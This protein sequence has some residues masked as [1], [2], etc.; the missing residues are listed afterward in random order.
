MLQGELAISCSLE[1]LLHAEFGYFTRWLVIEAEAER[2][3]TGRCDRGAGEDAG[4]V[5]HVEPVVEVANIALQAHGARFLFVEIEGSGEIHG[6][7]WAHASGVEIDAVDY[8]LAEF[9]DERRGCL[10]VQ[11]DR[12]AGAGNVAVRARCGAGPGKSRCG[13]W[14]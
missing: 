13:R 7:G 4:K 6:Q 11:F 3:G 8:G 12:K 2:E 14:S 1:A 5:D 9:F 10:A